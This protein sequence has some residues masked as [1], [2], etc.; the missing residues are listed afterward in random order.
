MSEFADKKFSGDNYANGRPNYPHQL[1][2]KLK[3]K[4]LSNENCKNISNP[5]LV[6]LGCGPGTATFQLLAV[7]FLNSPKAVYI[8]IDPSAKMIEA[9]EKQLA[10]DQ[11]SNV[12]FINGNEKNFDQ[13]LA[14]KDNITV[15]TAVQSCHWFNF[16]VFLDNAY[17]ILSKTKGSLFLYGYINVKLFEYPELDTLF[18]DLDKGLE[19]GFGAYWDQPGR[20]YLSEML[21]DDF[22]MKSLQESDFKN[23]S[24]DRFIVDE[25]RNPLEALDNDS[26]PDKPFYYLYKRTTMHHFKKYVETWS[27]YNRCKREKGCEFA[28]KLIDDA[29]EKAFKLVPGLSYDSP[30]TLAWSTYVISAAC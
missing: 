10:G 25:K 30:I 4:Y 24:V 6:D 2:E 8:G 26:I 28:D 14:A 16:P 18:N 20:N 22:F 11:T 5:V 29:F 17:K 12:K 23:V 19:T 7:D 13:I 3:S 1:Y 27:A 9:G 15:I 21:T